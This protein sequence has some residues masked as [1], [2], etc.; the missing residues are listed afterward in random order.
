[1]NNPSTSLPVNPLRHTALRALARITAIAA[2]LALV[3]AARAV[4]IYDN[5]NTGAEN[6]A[7]GWLHITDPNFASHTTYTFPTDPLGGRAYRM[8][9]SPPTIPFND[10]SGYTTARAT[11]I[12]TAGS[13]SDF[14]MAADLVS[15]NPSTEEHTNMQFIG[16]VARAS[17]SSGQLLA[18]GTNFNAV[19][20]VFAVNATTQHTNDAY[21][22]SPEGPSTG[23]LLMGYVMNGLIDLPD[24]NGLDGLPM[25]SGVLPS[26]LAYWTLVPG[27]S[28][29]M[30]FQ[31][32]GTVLTGKLYDLQDLTQPIGTITGDTSI[33]NAYLYGI[34]PI[35][36]PAPTS[37]YCGLFAGGY[38]NH[39]GSPETNSVTVDATFDNFYAASTVPAAP[40]SPPA[41]PHGEIG[42]PQVKDRTP[43]SWANFYSAASGIT[44]TA[45]TLTTTNAIN[46][47]GTRLI[48][49]GVDASPS[50][51]IVSQTSPATNVTF[52][53]G[54]AGSGWGLA[55]NCVYDAM[56]ILQDALGRRTTNAWTFDTFSDAYLANRPNIECEDYDYVSGGT[57]GQY[58]NF[59]VPAS[60]FSTNDNTWYRYDPWPAAPLG[61]QYPINSLYNYPDPVSNPGYVGLQGV[62][63]NGGSLTPTYFCVRTNI[64]HGSPLGPY[65]LVNDF[66]G[67]GEFDLYSLFPACEYRTGYGVGSTNLYGDAVGTVEGAPYSLSLLNVDITNSPGA[68]IYVNKVFDT[69]RSKYAA[70][71]QKG[72]DQWQGTYDQP[73]NWW[74]VEEYMVFATDGSDWFNYTK[75]WGGTA[76]N[77]NVYLRHACAQSQ[78]LNLYLG[79]TT[80]RASQLGT[81]YCTNAL[82]WNFRYAPLVDANNKLAVVSLGGGSQPTT[83]RLEVAPSSA[84]FSSV[85]YMMAM[86]YLAFVPTNRPLLVTNFV[87]STSN[88]VTSIS[89][90]NNGKYTV[91]MRG[92]PGAQYYLVTSP[93]IQT[94]MSSW[95][96]VAGSTNTAASDGTWSCVVSNP[97]T[98]YYR[99]KA[100]HPAF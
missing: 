71:N 32:V 40:P 3:A 37:G 7:A 56:I 24:I 77:Y 34:Q 9:A 76:T 38:K 16:L 62:N 90:Q 33:G 55:S 53:L 83:L 64:I 61:Y 66:L 75:N 65:D 54:G 95:T 68:G 67:G 14:Y 60:G 52:S 72:H 94:V 36:N 92:T 2:S 10:G 80:N 11:A 89:N 74:D 98:V 47:N 73:V 93:N 57:S 15:W 12:A 5:F 29:R 70:L 49:N 25:T 43:A 27:H 21:T 6:P 26:A 30:V 86:N 44:F 41:T 13:F 4:V 42:A 99:A 8:Q 78:E 22:G 23:A 79:A 84:N 46:V 18:G 59:P 51:V 31:G 63:A 82:M 87:I 91:T 50:L 28:Y 100:I 88:V 19:M 1:M 96:P 17:S 58:F 69:K 35:A 39:A 20:L 81:F 45:T 97:A 85:Q 48:L